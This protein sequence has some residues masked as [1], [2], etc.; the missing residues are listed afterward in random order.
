MKH[1]N[2]TPADALQ[3]TPVVYMDLDIVEDDIEPPTDD[4][5][6]D[7]MTAAE[8]CGITA[9]PSL[10]AMLLTAHGP[11]GGNPVYRIEGPLPVMI[12]WMKAYYCSDEEQLLFFLE[13]AKLA[14]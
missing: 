5:D 2:V 9:Y 14:R 4:E 12:K 8:A 6:A 3:V 11:G 13:Q 10:K 7:K 1:G